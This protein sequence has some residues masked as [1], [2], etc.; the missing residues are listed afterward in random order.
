M[1]AYV[2]YEAIINYNKFTSLPHA[3]II[4]KKNFKME[5][6]NSCSIYFLYYYRD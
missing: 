5:K 4:E 6:R 1:V 2:F 3:Q